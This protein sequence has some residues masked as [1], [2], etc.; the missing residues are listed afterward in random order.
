MKQK[1]QRQN[2]SRLDRDIRDTRLNLQRQTGVQSGK[3]NR[4]YGAIGIAVALLLLILIA[5][6]Y[7]SLSSSKE[8][9]VSS[10]APDTVVINFA[11][12][13]ITAG[14]IDTAELQQVQTLIRQG[15]YN[16]GVRQRRQIAD[17]A[18]TSIFGK[19]EIAKQ[20]K[21]Y[22]L[23]SNDLIN[24]IAPLPTIDNKAAHQFYDAHPELFARSAPLI[25]I[26][27][28]VVQDKTLATHLLEQLHSGAS[29]A[30]LAQQY[31]LDPPQYRDQGGD[32]G[33]VAQGQMPTEWDDVA[34]SLAP[35][36]MSE[37]FQ[38]HSQYFI[39]QMM[40]K[41]RYDVILFNELSPS[42]NVIAAHYLQQ[43]QFNQWLSGQILSEPI[44]AVKP[45]Y[46]QIVNDMTQDVKN[47]PNQDFSR[48][49][50]VQK[51]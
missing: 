6:I 15:T 20:S 18:L 2:A 23:S 8:S 25:H 7:L 45:S 38:A 51:S 33:W 9:P 3:K 1:S 44:I 37:V 46:I 43:Q 36:Q 49:V 48:I 32:L 4:L 27:E 19:L 26:R 47:Y 35:D 50:D 29:F 16:N 24:R 39:I 13:P 42:A 28:I 10:I 41:P 21:Q 22:N 5:G 12:T 31:S 17:Y 14:Q 11:G 30:L 40:D 34:F